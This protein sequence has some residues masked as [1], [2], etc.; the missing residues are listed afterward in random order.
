MNTELDSKLQ[1]ALD[2]LPRSVEPSRDLW[3]GI[4]G[5]LSNQRVPRPQ[6]LWN[7]AMAAS[8]LIGV[9]AAGLWFSLSQ[10]LAPQTVN[11]AQL[12]PANGEDAYLL[13]RAAFAERSIQNAPNLAPATRTVIMNN[14]KII[15]NSIA[16]IQQAVIH[17]PS[18]P[19][20]QG[21]LTSLYQDE[22]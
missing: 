16:Q 17:D 21:L 9:G 19:Q 2:R 12:A 5:S 3:P 6:P 20:L 11:V 15:E 8:L 22:A 4:A 10:R 7:Y 14:L 1:R 18:N 13:Q